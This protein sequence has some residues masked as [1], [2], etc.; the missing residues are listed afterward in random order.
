[1]GYAQAIFPDRLRCAGISLATHSIGHALL[2]QR[3]GNVYAGRPREGGTEP[4][5]GA[6]MQALHIC[7][8]PWRSAL[9]RIDTRWEWAWMGWHGFRIPSIEVASL[10]F[11]AYLRDAWPEIS[12]WSQSDGKTRSLG[13]ELLHIHIAHQ[14]ASGL[15]IEQALDVPLAIAH[16]DS[17][18]AAE[19]SGAGSIRSATDQHLLDHFDRLKAT[20]ALPA[21]GTV[22]QR[23]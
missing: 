13:A 1:M 17:A 4:E 23:N 14:R 5:V 3:L 16:W 10:E 15:T 19:R 11:E 9:A 21:A 6:L 8:R 2:L 12:W 22:I 7:A 18:A 20:G